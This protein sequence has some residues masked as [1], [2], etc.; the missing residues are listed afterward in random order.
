MASG[1]DGD[2]RRLRPLWRCRLQHSRGGRLEVN[3]LLL[4]PDALA[5]MMPATEPMAIGGSQTSVQYTPAIGQILDEC[6]MAARHT[7]M[8]IPPLRTRPLFQ[9]LADGRSASRKAAGR[10]TSHLDALSIPGGI[11]SGSCIIRKTNAKAAPKKPAARFG[12]NVTGGFTVD[13]CAAQWEIHRLSRRTGNV[14]GSPTRRR[15]MN[16]NMRNSPPGTPA[17]AIAPAA[18]PGHAWPSSNRIT[19]GP[20]R[21][22]PSPNP[23]YSVAARTTLS[24][25]PESIEAAIVRVRVL[26]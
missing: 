23:E 19:K 26:L 22:D 18:L 6:N 11:A 20:R 21:P 7:P 1:P 24:S 25:L 17:T 15:D 12:V 8:K 5:T 16:H 4:P 2:V 9:A 14:L 3:Q 13:F 10:R